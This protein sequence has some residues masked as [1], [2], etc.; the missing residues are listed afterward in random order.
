MPPIRHIAHVINLC[1]VSDTRSRRVVVYTAPASLAVRK[2]FALLIFSTKFSQKMNRILSA[3][4]TGDNNNRTTQRTRNKNQQQQQKAKAKVR[5][6]STRPAYQ[7]NNSCDHTETHPRSRQWECYHFYCI[8][9]G[10]RLKNS[11]SHFIIMCKVFSAHT[12]KKKQRKVT[13]AEEG[14]Q[15]RRERT[16][17]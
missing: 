12:R 3:A 17:L 7:S 13:N 16:H 14:K 4:L 10:A 15:R 11:R 1:V 5:R 8:S 2:R 9:Q 6:R